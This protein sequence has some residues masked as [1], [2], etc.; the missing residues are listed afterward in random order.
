MNHRLRTG[1]PG[2]ALGT[3]TLTLIH[4]PQ[5]HPPWW[6]LNQYLLLERNKQPVLNLILV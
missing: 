6:K 1:G 2:L 4:V 3:R 5:V